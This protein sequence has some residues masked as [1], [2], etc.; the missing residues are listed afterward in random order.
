MIRFTDCVK[1]K[2]LCH[3][4]RLVQLDADTWGVQFHNTIVIRIHRD[5]SY[6]LNSGGYRTVTTKKRLNL[7]GP[8]RVSQ[9]AFEWFAGDV[10]FT[11]GMKV[12]A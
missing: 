6:T 4:T 2:K 8:V 7:Y 3:N 10:P 9:R 5:G 11:D 12:T 1:A